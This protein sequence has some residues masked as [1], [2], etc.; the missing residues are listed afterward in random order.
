[1]VFIFW[2]KVWRLRLR[3]FEK[4]HLGL[5]QNFKLPLQSCCLWLS[6]VLYMSHQT[7]VEHV[8]ALNKNMCRL[9]SPLFWL[10]FWNLRPQKPPHML[11]FGAWSKRFSAWRGSS[12]TPWTATYLI[13]VAVPPGGRV[14]KY[15]GWHSGQVRSP[16]SE[17]AYVPPSPGPTTFRYRLAAPSHTSSSFSPLPFSFLP[18]AQSYPPVCMAYRQKKGGAKTYLKYSRLYI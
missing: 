13:R 3:E 14:K 18:P 2:P 8:A 7:Y 16:G 1:M 5:S 6:R 10:E 12:S 9:W 11:V 17:V 15:F 4:P